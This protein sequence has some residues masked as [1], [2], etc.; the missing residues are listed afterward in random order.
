MPILVTIS[1]PPGRI[2]VENWLKMCGVSHSSSEAQQ[3]LQRWQQAATQGVYANIRANPEFLI[4]VDN[5]VHAAAYNANLLAFT[6]LICISAY[7]DK[8]FN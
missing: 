3:L 8:P 7:V 4:R 5:M 6:L 1:V 2:A